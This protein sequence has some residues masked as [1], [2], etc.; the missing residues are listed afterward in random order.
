MTII[1]EPQRPEPPLEGDEARTLLG[2]LEFLRATLEWKASGLGPDGLN[3]TVGASAITLGGLLKHLALVEDYWFAVRL[4]G[5]D[6]HADWRGI[7]WTATPDWE[8]ESAAAD[9]PDELLARWQGAVARSRVL[10]ADALAGGDL[11]QLAAQASGTGERPSLRWIL[12][13]MIEEY[14]RHNGHA[15][16]VRESIDGLTGE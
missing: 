7:D 6:P 10:V 12:V 5:H 9:S 3:A 14:A 1:D 4:H 16:L 8:W 11:G 2:F 15:D 13:H